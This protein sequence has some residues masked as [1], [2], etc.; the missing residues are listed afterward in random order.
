MPQEKEPARKHPKEPE[1][2]HPEPPR[3]APGP[4]KGHPVKEVLT[5]VEKT[6][7]GDWPGPKK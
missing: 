7:K 5:E 4:K 3:P 1:P 6:K 2:R